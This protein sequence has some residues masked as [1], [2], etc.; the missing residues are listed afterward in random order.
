M[1]FEGIDTYSNITLNGEHI[2]QTEN[3]FRRYRVDVHNLLKEGD[4]VLEVTIFPATSFDD[5]G[6]VSNKMPFRYAHTRKACYQYS[7]DWAPELVTLGIWKNVY[8]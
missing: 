6:Q 5:K 2:L 3:A 4:N 8:L 7:W 1:T